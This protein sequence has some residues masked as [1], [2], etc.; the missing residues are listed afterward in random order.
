MTSASK[1]D[2]AKPFLGAQ[3]DTEFRDSVLESATKA[4]FFIRLM[5]LALHADEAKLRTI[6]L[7]L[8]P[9]GLE[10][11]NLAAD[12]MMCRD[13]LQG[14]AN[15]MK[16]AARRVFLT[17]EQMDVFPP[18]PYHPLRGTKTSLRFPGEGKGDQGRRSITKAETARRSNARGLGLPPSI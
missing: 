10:T 7:D 4:P 17:L 2:E 5:A 18:A 8:G 1:T 14:C 16:T 6:L 3:I 12:F 9:D 13:K 15:L 11:E